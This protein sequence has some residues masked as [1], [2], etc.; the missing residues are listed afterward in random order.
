MEEISKGLADGPYTSHDLDCLFGR[1]E[2]CPMRRFMHVQSCGKLR[3]IDDGRSSG[4]NAACVATE[5]IYTSSPDFVAAAAKGLLVELGRLWG[6]SSDWAHPVFGTED[7]SSAYRQ[8][9]NLPS[10][11]S[12]LVLAFCHPEHEAVRYALLRAWALQ[13]LDA[14]AAPV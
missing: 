11:A 10:E 12:G 2:W 1:S 3:P 7:M 5:T 4:H 9:P 14:P 6:G 8:L 13:R